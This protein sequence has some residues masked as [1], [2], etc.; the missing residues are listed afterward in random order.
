[1]TVRINKQKINLREK[2]AETEEKVSFDE[3]VRG[4]GEYSGNV[5]IGTTSDGFKLNV[6]SSQYQ[7]AKFTRSDGDPHLF[8]E[9]TTHVASDGVQT[10]CAVFLASN[11]EFRLSRRAG[12]NIT[13]DQNVWLAGTS[14][15]NVGIGTDDPQ[16]PLE[17]QGQQ[18]YTDS[19]EDLETSVTKSTLRIKGSSDS[20]DSLFFGCE[21]TDANPYIQAT[22]GAGTNADKKL[23]LNPWGGNVG[24]GTADPG[25]NKLKVE[26]G[27]RAER[28]TS[29]ASTDGSA[30][31]CLYLANATTE[32]PFIRFNAR[33]S[34]NGINWSI[35][36]DDET[37]TDEKNLFA[38]KRWDDANTLKD[39]PFVIDSEGN[40][41]IG[42]T[43]PNRKLEVVEDSASYPA[44]IKNTATNPFGL[45]VEY[46]HG[47]DSSSGNPFI[48]CT[49]EHAVRMRVYSD[50]DVYTA[51]VG[52]LSS[53][54]RLKTN[55]V[56]AT[57]KLEDIKK[58]KVRNF[59]WVPEFH[60][61]KEGE[62]KIGFIA[63]ELEK[64]FPGL[65]DEHDISLGEEEIKRKS[66]RLG[67]LIPILVKGIQEQQQT[68]EDLKSRIETL[69]QQ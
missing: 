23:L 42:T 13:Q 31:E 58:L 39:T 7:T 34:T 2:L 66:V 68:I 27:L 16:S 49:D 65:V 32:E 59:E 8:F 64:V 26:G 17:V 29:I 61:S 12:D 21:Q 4:L 55:I 37:L 48:V 60:P 5:G 33:N 10:D 50:G 40:V 11:S 6:L 15:G 62:K 24:I 57:P 41:G 56:D 46:T 20:S 54:E 22:N 52:T 14:G 36:V 9:N 28:V 67:A 53:D 30:S 3:V 38:F 35:G 44:K 63:Q 25:T 51:D 47:T 19:A 45:L 43:S 18:A 69:E 1:M